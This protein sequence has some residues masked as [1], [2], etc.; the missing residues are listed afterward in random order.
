LAV[1]LT[2]IAIAAPLRTL[3]DEGTLDT[4]LARD[5]ILR[6]LVD[7]LERSAKELHLSDLAKPYFIEY[8]AQDGC[9]AFASAEF[10]ALTGSAKVTRRPLRVDVRVGSYELDNTN[11]REG[12]SFGGGALPIENDYTAIRQAIWWA[13]DRE[14]KQ[15]AENY[16]RKKAFME[17]KIIED[18]PNDFSREEPV[19][20]FEEPLDFQVSLADLENIVVAVSAVFRDFPDIQESS[21]RIQAGGGTGYL[22]NTEGTRLRE[23]GSHFELTATAS[24]QADDGMELSDALTVVAETF[25]ELPPLEELQGRSRQLADRL[26]KLKNA[27]R[28]DEAY[29]GPALVAAE[30][31]AALFGLQFSQNFAGGQRPVGTRTDPDDFERRIGKRILPRSVTVLDDPTQK[32]ISGTYVLG[33]YRHDDQGVPA[34]PVTL[35]ESGRLQ[36]LVM[37]RNPSRKF[38]KSTGHGN[39]FFRP[40]ASTACLI[41]SSDDP[42]DA[43]TLRSELFEAAQDED[44]DYAIR[45]ASY[46]SAGPLEAYKVYPDGREELLRGV[47][48]ARVNLRA[49]KRIIAVGD[50]PHVLNVSSRLIGQTF[51][52]PALLFEELDIAPADRDF[53]KPPLLPSPLAQKDEQP[54]AG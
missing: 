11:H 15:V 26:I 8:A 39:G 2:F 3:A 46:G 10:G 29:S 6:A 50:T 9:S 44:L 35:V 32:R 48:G 12:W 34:Q 23:Q 25:A 19:R 28:L 14:Y 17:Q 52:V 54:T 53:D 22:V 24:V 1:L 31:A 49:F 51:V 42:A 7:E 21:V 45:I 20:D 41:L 47:E 13:T 18:K 4:E 30:P 40:M 37:S 36:R 5:V 33:S 38:Q 43:A 16:A 27:P